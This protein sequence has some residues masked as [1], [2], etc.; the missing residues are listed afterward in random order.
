MD[1]LY[2]VKQPSNSTRQN[3]QSSQSYSS[4]QAAN[5]FLAGNGNSCN[6]TSQF[7]GGY[8]SIQNNTQSPK[9]IFSDSSVKEDNHYKNI[10]DKYANVHKR[11]DNEHSNKGSFVE[12]EPCLQNKI[13]N[14]VKVNQP[15]QNNLKGI[16][17][18]G[19]QHSNNSK[20]TSSSSKPQRDVK[21]IIMNKIHKLNV[22]KIYL[23]EDDLLCDI[24]PSELKEGDTIKG[25]TINLATE[26]PVRQNERNPLRGASQ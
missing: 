23:K 25:H 3:Y 1:I 9:K 10:F 17:L 11:N 14:E 21:S 4:Q 18:N 26:S 24:N 6:N 20:K 7:S 22:A 15:K 19:K 2:S 12:N 5:N 13:S 16:N 8:N